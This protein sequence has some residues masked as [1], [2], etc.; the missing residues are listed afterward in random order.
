MTGVAT[1]MAASGRWRR[2][3]WL[4]PAAAVLAAVAV[5]LARWL[6]TLPEVQS[7]LLVY[8]GTAPMPDWAP[9][10]I[11]AWLA[12]QHFLNAFFLV[13]IVRSGW[14][15]RTVSRP[16]ATWMRTNTGVLR[17][18]Q[19]PKKISIHQWLHT[20]LDLLWVANGVIF[21]VVLFATGQWAR[22]VP[23]SWEV[24][25]NALS[26]VLQYASFDWP[27]ENGWVAYNALQQL[28]YFGVVFLL[29]PLAIVTGVRMAE[30]WPVDS[31]ISG[32]YRV[33]WARAVHF[34][35]MLL[36]VLFVIVHVVLV[37]ATGAQRNLNHMFAAS[38]DAT[39]WWGVGF[40]AGSLV[41]MAVAVVAAQPLVIRPVA[42]AFGKVG[43]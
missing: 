3:Y 42:A 9:V 32:W 5:F 29:A 13:L 31:R 11:P 18:R 8:D 1:A 23:T 39:S 27:V 26:A 20:S 35:V 43:R 22:I 10:G 15:V 21:V 24:V 6:R 16:P 37:L 2:L 4:V 36:F 41:V 30:F 38:D 28:S 34:P 19:A 14:Q 12:W 40:F 7:W 25:P 33:E 17:T